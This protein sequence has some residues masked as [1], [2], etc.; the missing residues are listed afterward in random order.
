MNWRPDA[1]LNPCHC[2]G[3][4]HFMNDSVGEDDFYIEWIYCEAC[5]RVVPGDDGNTDQ[6]VMDWNAGV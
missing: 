3:K 5:G 1:K 6:L 4:A 2:G